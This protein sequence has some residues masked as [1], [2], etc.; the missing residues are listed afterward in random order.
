MKKRTI[1]VPSRSYQP[2]KA[3]REEVFRI[4]ATPTRLAKALLKP[5]EIKERG[6]L[7]TAPK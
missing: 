6:R 5:V 4:D 7:K 3:E 2:T 1:N